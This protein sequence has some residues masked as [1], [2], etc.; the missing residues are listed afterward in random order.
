MSNLRRWI[1]ALII[2]A[3]LALLD[4][5]SVHLV[6]RYYL[7]SDLELNNM[8][9]GHIWLFLIA[10]IPYSLSLSL[11]KHWPQSKRVLGLLGVLYTGAWC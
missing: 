11:L 5:L 1:C 3:N 9:W 7:L 2:H 10:T 8:L 4:I 6:L